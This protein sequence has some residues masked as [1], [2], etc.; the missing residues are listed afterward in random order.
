MN[1]KYLIKA[2]EKESEDVYYGPVWNLNKMSKDSINKKLM[3]SS[4]NLISFN[5]WVDKYNFEIMI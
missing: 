3:D 5:D 2:T 1:K 4:I